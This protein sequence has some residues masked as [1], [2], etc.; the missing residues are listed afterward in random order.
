MQARRTKLWC[1]GLRNSRSRGRKADRADTGVD[2]GV[3]GPLGGALGLGGRSSAA[4][5]FD[6]NAWLEVIPFASSTVAIFSSADL[7]ICD[8]RL[9]LIPKIPPI[10]F[11]VISLV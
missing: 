10:S 9:S 3:L 7:W 6:Q 11:I 4:A 1:S 8:T 5:R 2:T